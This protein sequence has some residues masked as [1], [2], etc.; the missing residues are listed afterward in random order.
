MSLR[1]FSITLSVE[2]MPMALNN[3]PS[4]LAT[5]V[6]PVPGLPVRIMFTGR[7]EALPPNSMRLRWKRISSARLLMAALTE[8]MP[9]NWSSSF[10]TCSTLM[11]SLSSSPTMSLHISRFFCFSYSSPR[12]SAILSPCLVTQLSKVLRT[13]LALPKVSVRERYMRSKYLSIF[14]SLSSSSFSLFFSTMFM[15]M[16]LSSLPL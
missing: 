5:E 2:Q 13:A 10:M 16:V 12:R 15:N 14:D 6:F 11:S 3:L 7:I 8:P 9:T 1:L 4:T